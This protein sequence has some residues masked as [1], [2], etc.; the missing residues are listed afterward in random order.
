[1]KKM[2]IC[3][4]SV[5]IIFISGCDDNPNISVPNFIPK[6]LPDNFVETGIDAHSDNAIYLEW[7]EPSSA[8]NEGILGY[9]LYRGLFTGGEYKFSKLATIER[10]NV[11][12][13]PSDSYIDYEVSL[14]T[15]YYYYL[16]AYNDFGVSRNTSD[17][18]FYELTY[19]PNLYEPLGQIT[20]SDPRFYFSYGSGHM[21]RISYMYLRLLYNEGGVFNPLLFVK[22]E[23]YDLS[24][25]RFYV[26]LNQ[27]DSH[28]FV[29][30]D[31][32]QTDTSGTK[33]LEKGQYKWR[34]D[35][36]S[37]E[38]YGNPESQ[39]SESNWGYFEVK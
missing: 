24:N 28:T 30:L 2:I 17:T 36:V 13:S 32:L 31:S 19:K 6:S 37:S 35:A 39:G 16:R 8:E 26:Y 15:M 25:G 29:L 27:H 14:D 1:M 23:R 7:N 11:A 21:D 33:Y 38:A 4:M 9:Y 20:D 12:V 34:V 5:I 10:G 18:V 3:F 22:R